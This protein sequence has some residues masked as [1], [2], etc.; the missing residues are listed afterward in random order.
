[1]DSDDPQDNV[2]V[3]VAPAGT[4]T[5]SYKIV[6]DHMGGTHWYHAHVH[7]NT[8]LQVGNGLVGMMVVEDATDEIP[9]DLAAL[10]ELALM[11]Q[12]FEPKATE[13]IAAAFANGGDGW[14]QSGNTGGAVQV[15]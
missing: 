8:A 9:A 4:H 1:M 13:T 5:Y 12:K 15:E 7:G 3:S 2:Y 10:S 6:S 11:I 14:T